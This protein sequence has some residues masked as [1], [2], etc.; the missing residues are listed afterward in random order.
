MENMGGWIVVD[1]D[2]PEAWRPDDGEILTGSV[3]RIG[4]SEMG[5]RGQ[6]PWAVVRQTES[7][8]EC[9]VWGSARLSR[10]IKMLE[11]GWE[12]RIRFDGTSQLPGG[13][14]RLKNYTVAYRRPEGGSNGQ[15]VG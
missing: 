3:R 7:G 6:V 13:K 15:H 1:L 4:E 14:K 5:E 8:E 12:I 9:T 2:L 10:F 11:V